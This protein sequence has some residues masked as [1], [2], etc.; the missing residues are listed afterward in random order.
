MNELVW[1]TKPKTKTKVE[2]KEVNGRQTTSPENTMNDVWQKL[3]KK[4]EQ[5]WCGT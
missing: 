4:T 1:G 3:I 2:L 5:R